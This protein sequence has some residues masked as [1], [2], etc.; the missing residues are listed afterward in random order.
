M[1]TLGV[2][3][4]GLLVS[5][6]LAVRWGDQPISLR[7]AFEDP[8]STD[9][10]ILFSLRVPRVL[11]AALVGAALSASGTALQALTRNALA[12]PFV[13][14]VSGGA[15][16]GATLALALGWSFEGAWVSVP[17]AFAFLGALLATVL[18]F[19]AGARNGK[20]ATS[21][22]LTGVIFNSLAAAL[23]TCIKALTAPDKVGD[24]LHWLAGALGYEK[25][26]TLAWAFGYQAGALGVLWALSGRLN[27]LALGDDEAGSLGVPVAQT[28]RRV[29]GAASFSVAGAV[30]LSGLVGFVGLLVPHILRRLLGPDQ[31]LLLPASAVGGACFLVLADWGAR[32]LFRAFHAEPPVGVVTAA[33]G[34][35]LFLW[36][37]HRPTPL[38]APGAKAKDVE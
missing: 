25:A 15:A 33:I 27:L 5:C 4:A 38:R 3:G 14:G 6:L 29:L 26:S 11:L 13:L 32:L 1:T 19:F 35:P 2:L 31:R 10:A 37:L 21:V 24:I 23:I 20:S 22:L 28:R 16:L 7:T 34:G 18:V 30:A 8:T 17:S 36:L 12:D 9:A